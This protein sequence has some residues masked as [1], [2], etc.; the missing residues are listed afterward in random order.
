MPADP[1]VG[2]MNRILSYGASANSSL[3]QRT[4]P[5]EP[6]LGTHIREAVEI[7]RDWVGGPRET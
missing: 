3:E 1:T 4:V 6:V 7:I 2:D 5:E